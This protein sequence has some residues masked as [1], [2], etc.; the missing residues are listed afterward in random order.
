MTA[1]QPAVSVVVPVFN[2]VAT[3]DDCVRSLLELRY[4]DDRLELIVVDN[5]SHDGTTQALRDYRHRIV[6]AHARRRGAASA[7]NA[8]VRFASGEVIAFTDADCV[9]EPDWLQRLVDALE[10]PRVGIAG[11][12]IR[13]LPN[14]NEIERFGEVIHDHRAAMEV[15]KPPYAITMSWGSRRAL[16]RSLGG[17]DERFRRG[18]DVDLAYRIV[19]SGFI[20]VFVPE[21][22]VYHRNEDTLAGLFREGFQH[23][24]CAVQVRKRHDALV[25]DV[26]YRRVRLEDYTNILEG[27]LRSIRG[28]GDVRSRCEA[29]FNAGKKVGALAGSIRFCRLDL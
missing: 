24:F 17:F 7:R 18:Q 16:L 9:V 1:W 27:L 8:G 25:A 23:G 4:P 21:A 26:G 15:Y 20:L 19:R 11:G 5:G 14:A 3:I 13:A 29:V 22:I 2:G 10:D 12:P 6:V 28:A